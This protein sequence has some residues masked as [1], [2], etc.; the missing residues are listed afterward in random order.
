MGQKASWGAYLTYQ[1]ITGCQVLPESLSLYLLQGKAGIPCPYPQLPS[2][3]VGLPFPQLPFWPSWLPTPLVY[4]YSP[5]LLVL[6]LS[7][8]CLLTQPSSGSYPHQTLPDVPASGCALSF[9][10]YKLSPPRNLGAFMSFLYISV[11]HLLT[12]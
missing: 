7:R 10:R 5:D 4:P 2:L 8:L 12:F 11:F 3:E 6:S 1:G 9:T